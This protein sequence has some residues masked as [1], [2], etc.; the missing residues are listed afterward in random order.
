[1]NEPVSDVESSDDE[2]GDHKKSVAES[3]YEQEIANIEKLIKTLLAAKPQ[4]KGQTTPS[5]FSDETAAAFRQQ[6][7]SNADSNN[8]QT[9]VYVQR[10]HDDDDDYN[11]VDD[12]DENRAEDGKFANK[13]PPASQS[14]QHQH[15]HKNSISNIIKNK[16]KESDFNC[17]STPSIPTHSTNDGNEMNINDDSDNNAIEKSTTDDYGNQMEMEKTQRKKMARQQ[18]TTQ[19]LL[20]NNANEYHTNSNNN[21]DDYVG[22]T[23]ASN[24][25]G[26]CGGVNDVDGDECVE[27]GKKKFPKNGS[28]CC[29]KSENRDR[30]TKRN[31]RWWCHRRSASADSGSD[32]AFNCDHKREP[33]R[34]ANPGDGDPTIDVRRSRSRRRRKDRS[35]HDQLDNKRNGE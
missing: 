20:S 11:E 1:L 5:P 24:C 15:K 32:A 8:N 13:F 25:A 7:I 3:H 9:N 4:P 14:S 22:N 18:Q 33:Y 35:E 21:N 27:D 12:D 28:E 26:S 6:R 19:R 29:G 23:A 30:S 31:E 16:L 17:C 2:T 34:W 10:Y